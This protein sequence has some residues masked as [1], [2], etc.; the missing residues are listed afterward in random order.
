MHI[1]EEDISSLCCLKPLPSASH[2]T[3]FICNT[4]SLFLLLCFLLS[5]LLS[6]SPHKEGR[7]AGNR[8]GERGQYVAEP[9]K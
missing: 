2:S 1:D 7:A 9:R 6:L 5:L 8:E 3:L 4:G